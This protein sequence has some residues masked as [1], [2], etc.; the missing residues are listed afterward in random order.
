MARLAALR[1][2]EAAPARD[3][4]CGFAIAS[5]CGLEMLFATYQGS[6][7]H[8]QG[9]LENGRAIGGSVVESE[10]S[11]LPEIVAELPLRYPDMH[12]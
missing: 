9:R 6:G 10:A 1:P 4:L 5:L 2:E 7:R 3:L 11:P 12:A 8:R